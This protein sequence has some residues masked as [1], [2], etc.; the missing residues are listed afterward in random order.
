MHI[1]NDRGQPAVSDEG[2]IDPL[3]TPLAKGPP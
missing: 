2:L 1:R 3:I